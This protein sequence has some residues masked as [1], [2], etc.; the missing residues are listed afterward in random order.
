MWPYSRPIYAGGKMLAFAANRGH[1]ADIG[2]MAAGGWAGSAHHV[3]QEA[4]LIPPVK[5]YREGVVDRQIKDF[6]LSNVRIPQQAWGTL[7]GQIASL[8]V[9]ERR[10]GTIVDKYGLDAVEQ[11]TEDYLQYA[12]TRFL[13]GLQQIPNGRWSAEEFMDDDGITEG[14]HRYFVTLEKQGRPHHCR[15]HRF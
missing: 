15:L 1:W 3:I 6:V 10:V 9:A 11:A 5:L 14:P 12:R 7:Q 2:G 8:I 4:L 13:K